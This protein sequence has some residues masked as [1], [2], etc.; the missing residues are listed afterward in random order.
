MVTRRHFLGATAAAAVAGPAALASMLGAARATRPNILFI[1][2]DDLGYGDL[3]SF[4][5]P[6]Y[7]TP[8]IDRL[9]REGTRLTSVY[10]AHCVCTPTRVALMT[11]RYPA[12][13]PVGL[14]EPIDYGV[15]DVVGLPPDHPTP[16][17]LLKRAGYDTALVGKWHFGYRPE[18]GPLRHGFDEFFG[19]LSG[20]V[21][22]FSHQDR[23]GKL[24]LYENLD[25]VEKVGYLT[26]LLTERAVQ[27][28][29]RRHERPYYLA[30]HFNAPHWPWE[31]PHDRHRTDSLRE[32]KQFANA[33]GSLRVYA[34]MMRSLDDGVGRVLAALKKS[35]RERD[36]LVVFTSDNGGERYSFNWPASN[37][38]AT[39]WEGGI[40]VP[41]FVRWPGTIPAGRVSD[42]TIITMDWTATM[43]AAG[44]ASADP[45]YPLDGVDLLPLL[46]DGRPLAERTL[47][48]R[49]SNTRERA[50]QRAARAGRYKLLKTG[51]RE[52]LFDIAADPGEKGDLAA[53]LPDVL[54]RLRDAHARWESGMLPPRARG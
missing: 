51:D 29:G 37:M 44:G 35:G 41:A 14:E 20:G 25:P 15:P 10:T 54:A 1:L 11:G 18:Y 36:T 26:E 22:Y 13:L 17:S 45:A 53:A 3:S 7:R 9:A 34:E 27:Y 33:G 12:R 16:A 23:D 50:I 19:F 24:D 47:Y 43:L 39:L 21:D 49:A 8:H 31:G 40:R 6:D 30:L 42:E 46:R 4:G 38:K 52:Q 5:R 2:A 28:V 32:A 48:W